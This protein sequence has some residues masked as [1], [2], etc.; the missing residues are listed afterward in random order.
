M[1]STPSGDNRICEEFG[2]TRF[3]FFDTVLRIL[4]LNHPRLQSARSFAN[5]VAASQSRLF[6]IAFGITG[7]RTDAEDLV[8]QAI[9]IAIEKNQEFETEGQFVAWLS[10][11]VRNCSRNHIRKRGRRKTQATDPVNLGSVETNLPEE[12]PVDSAGNINPL[13]QSFDDRLQ[14]ALQHIKPQARCCLLLRTVEGLSY[15]EI[16][17]QMNI[18]EGSAMNM[19]HRSKKQLRQLLMDFPKE[20]S[21]G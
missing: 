14:A 16:S 19:V 4:K 17:Q 21:N 10:G 18:P 5:G 1:I 3:Q 12:R 11:I 9:T 6:S 13:Q 2:T 15:R 8:Q 7:N 20:V